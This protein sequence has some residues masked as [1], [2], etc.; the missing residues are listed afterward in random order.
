MVTDA[1]L[2]RGDT[3]LSVAVTWNYNEMYKFDS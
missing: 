1:W 2:D 3:P